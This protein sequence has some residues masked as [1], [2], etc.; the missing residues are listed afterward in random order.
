MPKPKTLFVCAECGQ[1][2]AR[3]LGKCPGCGAW[4]TLHEQEA[5]APALSQTGKPLKRPGGAGKPPQ[6]LHEIDD[7]AQQRRSCGIDELDRVLG[8]GIVEGSVMLVGGDPG[9]GKSTLLLQAC[10]HLADAGGKVLYVTGEESARQIKLRAR[11]LGV[12]AENLW[13]LAENA[14]DD[15][16]AQFLQLSPDFVVIDS[17]QTVYRPE[18]AAAPGSVSQVRECAA[19][20]IR[21]AKTTGCAMCLVGHV[22]KEGAIAGPRVLEHMVDAVLYFEGDRQHAWRVLRAAKNRF[23]S[24]NEIGLFEMQTNGMV[25]V[26][27]PSELLLSRRAQAASGSVITCAMEGLR[28]MLVDVQALVSRTPFGMPRRTADGL[29]GARVALLLAVLEKRLG[30]R[31]YDQ[32]VYVNVAGGLSLSEP[33]ADLPLLLAVAS[34]LRDKVLPRGLVV[35]GEVGLLGEVRAVAHAER[36]LAECARLGFT[37]CVLPRENLRNLR[38][39]EGIALHGVDTVAQALSAV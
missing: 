13:V 30:L 23:G 26:E 5:P 24:V 21:L 9:I 11:R 10:G 35:F 18:L 20:L 34:S 28:P 2:S 15:I 7:A 8:G 33:A 12:A 38:A 1:E 16:E 31:L 32:D 22:T 17:I 4:N 39:P 29:D 14:L 6:R 19:L 36:R 27:N 25:P 37:S 3:W